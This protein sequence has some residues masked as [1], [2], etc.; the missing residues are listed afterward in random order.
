MQIATL[1]VL[2]FDK[3]R[4]KARSVDDRPGECSDRFDRVM[5]EAR[6]GDRLRVLTE[7]AGNERA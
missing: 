2:P 6:P 7:E 1:V 4:F 3:K 5:S